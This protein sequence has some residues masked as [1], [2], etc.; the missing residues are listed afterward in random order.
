MSETETTDLPIPHYL[1]VDTTYDTYRQEIRALCRFRDKVNE[2]DG[3]DFLWLDDPA[4]D[5][6]CLELCE[7]CCQR[8]VQKYAKLKRIE[9]RY[10]EWIYHPG[11]EYPLMCLDC[12]CDLKSTV[13]DYECPEELCNIETEEDLAAWEA[14]NEARQKQ[15]GV[16][17]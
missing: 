11:N 8:L 9:V 1:V 15:Q 13:N 3:I 6:E 10:S 2:K 16:N 5:F 4:Q 17:Q 7:E 12:G 14:W